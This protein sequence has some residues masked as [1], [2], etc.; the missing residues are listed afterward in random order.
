MGSPSITRPDLGRPADGQPTGAGCCRTHR[1]GIAWRTHPASRRCS[2]G[3]RTIRAN[4]QSKWRQ[5]SSILCQKTM[6]TSRCLLEINKLLLYKLYIICHICIHA[7]CQN[8]R[9]ASQKPS[10]NRYFSRSEAPGAGRPGARWQSPRG[11][12]PH[13]TRVS[14]SATD[15]PRR[16][17]G[18]FDEHVV[19]PG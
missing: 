5:I 16:N 2:R 15:L 12:P 1:T 17:R 11:C 13:R 6:V 8:T 19:L 14:H 7:R 10:A 18:A 4:K 9:S 3:Q